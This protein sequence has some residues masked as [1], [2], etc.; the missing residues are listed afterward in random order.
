M[1]SSYNDYIYQ[2]KSGSTRRALGDYQNDRDYWIAQGGNPRLALGD[3]ISALN[4]G[5]SIQDALFAHSKQYAESPIV[6][7]ANPLFVDLFDST[8][9]TLSTRSGWTPAGDATR[10]D[11]MKSAD[12]IA[13]MNTGTNGDSPWG[14][15]TCAPTVGQYRRVTFGYDYSQQGGTLSNSG[16]PY[17]YYDQRWIL[18]YQDISNYLYAS[19]FSISAGVMQIRI[20]RTVANVDTEICRYVG[21]PAVGTATFI[22]TDRIRLYINGAIMVADQLYTDLQAAFPDKLFSASTTNAMR[23]GATALRHTFHPLVL[24][25]DWKVEDLDMTIADPKPFYGRTSANK[26]TITFN[27]TYV[28]SPVSWVYRLRR[29]STS[30]V[31][32]DWTAFS[33]TF[34]SGTWSADITVDSG[35][36]YLMD[37]GWVDATGKAHLTE[38]SPFA[39]GIL[40]C[41]WGQSNSVGGSGIGGAP[42]YGKNDLVIGFN[43]YATYVGSTFRRWVDDLT[44]QALALCPN[45]VGLAKSLSDATGIPV[46]VAATGVASNALATLKPGTSNWD[47]VLVP[48]VTEIGGNVE[49]WVWSQGEAEGLSAS[50]YSAY[51]TDFASLVTGMKS[52]GGRSDAKVFVRII[53]KDTSVANNSTT[54]TRSQAFRSILKNLENGTDIWVSSSFVGIP[55]VDQIHLTSAGA[56][57]AAYRDGLTIARRGYSAISYDGRGPLVTAS[58][59]VGAVIT[60][61][62]D[63]NGASG[64]TGSALTGYAVS[65]DD[66]VTTLTINSTEVV[67]NQIVITLA[68]V[69]TGTVKVRSFR[70]PNYTDSSVA[71][72]AYPGSVTIP[73]FPIIDP[74]TVT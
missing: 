29:R 49:Q 15:A 12:G 21:V 55:L 70:E 60:L 5:K 10:R 19:A 74:I 16:T 24:A 31:I 67:S 18:A 71:V 61:A 72:G 28:G 8:N 25:L 50:D 48:F 26:R 68:S 37:V 20:Y 73:V 66:F 56:V 47:T 14:Y 9:T 44:P 54:I 11:K 27:G 64:L 69:P 45:M 22:L 57:T 58:S 17:Q 30:A 33:P 40:V 36:P 53:G 65:N 34:G 4:P 32:K 43:G 3:M 2:I 35:G 6:V 38:S 13:R 62:M 1:P 63:L 41:M 42:G 46:G 52:V 51:V 39:V 23:S 59:R 7:A